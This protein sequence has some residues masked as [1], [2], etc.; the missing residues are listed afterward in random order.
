M[1]FFFAVGLLP[2]MST[3]HQPDVTHVIN[4]TRPSPF[5]AVSSASCIMQ[6]E[7][8]KMGELGLGTRLDFVVGCLCCYSSVE[9]QVY[10]LNNV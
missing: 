7:E 6:T 8:Q 10:P 4:E 3:L 5:F 9:M 1:H 2:L